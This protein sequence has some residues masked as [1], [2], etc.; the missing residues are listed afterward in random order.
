M[1]WHEVTE[2]VR[3]GKRMLYQ[4]PLDPRPVGVR[5][6]Y[7]KVTGQILVIPPKEADQFLAD[8]G[9]AERF[10]LKYPTIIHLPWESNTVRDLDDS[11]NTKRERIRTRCGRLVDVAHAIQFKEDLDKVTCSQCHGDTPMRKPYEKKTPRQFTLRINLGNSAMQ[12]PEDV[13]A[14]LEV[15]TNHLIEMDTNQTSG[16]IWDPNGNTVGGWT[17]K[18]P[19]ADEN[20]QR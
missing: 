11:G 5:C 13:A 9:H 8:E 6:R 7:Q 15:M 20:V 3:H 2:A 18:W 19:K 16:E 17:A 4:A 14:T 12:T 1:K 10:S